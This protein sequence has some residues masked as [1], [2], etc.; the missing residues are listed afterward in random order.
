MIEGGKNLFIEYRA[1]DGNDTIIGFNETSTL[2]IANSSYS[3]QIND[4][5]II[6]TVGE[7][8]ITLAGAASLSAVNIKKINKVQ[9]PIIKGNYI[10]NSISGALITDV[11]HGDIINSGA[12]VTI[13]GSEWHGAIDNSGN[14]VFISGGST[15][16]E[17]IHYDDT[18]YNVGSS[19][20]VDGG[21]GNDTISNGF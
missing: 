5:D 21:A 8:A 16:D 4:S 17:F 11:D 3:T 9:A 13:D 6:V 20:T 10:D 15:K 18:I 7:N 1:G 14:K 12:S 19:V 2:D